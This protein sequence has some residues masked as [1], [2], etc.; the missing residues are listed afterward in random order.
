MSLRSIVL[1]RYVSICALVALCFVTFDVSVVFGQATGYQVIPS[2]PSPL[3]NIASYCMAVKC[4]GSNDFIVVKASDPD[5]V[6]AERLAWEK[7]NLACPGGIEHTYEL[8]PRAC[9]L[10]EEPEVLPLARYQS[11][12]RLGSEWLLKASLVYCD[13]SPGFK[14][15]PIGGATLCEAIQNAKLV[16]CCDL[17]DPCKAAYFTYCI[18]KKPCQPACQ[19]SC[20]STC[21]PTCRPACR[22]TCQPAC[23]PRCLNF[24]R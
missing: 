19:P 14:D 6:E 21:Q 16:L 8:P 5:P 23:R 20:Q 10:I 1:G 12:T 9:R 22:P 3:Y 7:A 13:G 18:V 11:T 24:G 15:V 4:V 17:K 2:V